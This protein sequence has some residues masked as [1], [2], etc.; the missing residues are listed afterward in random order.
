MRLHLGFLALIAATIATAGCQGPPSDKFDGVYD[1]VTHCPEWAPQM[2]PPSD[3]YRVV[4]S[5]VIS[6]GLVTLRMSDGKATWSAHGSVDSA[7]WVRLVGTRT[8]DNVGWPLTLDI[9]GTII[10]GR[11]DLIAS[12]K[13]T[14]SLNCNMALT[15]ATSDRG[16]ILVAQRE[17]EQQRAAIDAERRKLESDQ[18]RLAESLKSAEAERERNVKELNAAQTESERAELRR[19]RETLA[20]RVA[21]LE[22]QLAAASSV[23][24]IPAIDP[25]LLKQLKSEKRLALVVGNGDYRGFGKLRNAVNDARAMSASLRRLGFDVTLVENADQRNLRR[26]VLE[27]GRKIERDSVGL[28]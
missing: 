25:A 24:A 19:Q 11:A 16:D 12:I 28:F 17:I 2:G 27:F 23:S 5:L 4:S 22:K 6:R 21:D 14:S 1:L 3:A 26:A 8:S 18:S 13:T 7:G 9:D 10:D 15:K 20:S